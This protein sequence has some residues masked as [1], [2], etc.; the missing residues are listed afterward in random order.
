M[1]PEVY[2][3]LYLTLGILWVAWN[4]TS[5]TF[6]ASLGTPTE[7]KLRFVWAQA[8]GIVIAVVLWPVGAMAWVALWA[9][10]LRE[11]FDKKPE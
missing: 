6:Q 7:R 10:R 1:G 5:Q 4:S 11:R 3:G 2:V 8:L 9:V